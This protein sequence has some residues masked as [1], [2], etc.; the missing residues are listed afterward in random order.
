MDDIAGWRKQI[1]EIDAQIVRLLNER[2]QCALEIGRIKAQH[3][4]KIFSPVR[5]QE[6]FTNIFQKNR[7]PLPDDAL[8]R[9]FK[10][11]VEECRN[12]E[13]NDSIHGL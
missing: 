1:D 2:A 10:R 12:L 9:L 4:M 6:I 5:E 13:K 8:L 11:I 7:G 3:G